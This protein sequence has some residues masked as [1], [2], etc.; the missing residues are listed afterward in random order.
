MTRQLIAHIATAAFVGR[1]AI[2]ELAERP[3]T[4]G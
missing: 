2:V 1:T 3:P 4:C